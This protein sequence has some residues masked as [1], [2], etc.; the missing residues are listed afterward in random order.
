MPGSCALVLRVPFPLRGSA[1]TFVE[2]SQGTDSQME[3]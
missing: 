1:R 3:F 2:C